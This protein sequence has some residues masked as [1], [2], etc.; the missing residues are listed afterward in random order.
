MFVY[1]VDENGNIESDPSDDVAN[2]QIVRE[3]N[4][5]LTFEVDD[6]TSSEHLAGSSQ[7]KVLNYLQF[8]I[9]DKDSNGI[10][11]PSDDVATVKVVRYG[12]AAN[13]KLTIRIS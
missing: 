3:T 10:L 6:T 1:D 7:T 12:N 9:N 8:A 11:H 2:I 5:T 4:G 13:R